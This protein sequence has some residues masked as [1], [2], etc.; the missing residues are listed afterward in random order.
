MA[1]SIKPYIQEWIDN[2]HT[3]IA[4][5][6]KAGVSE[7]VVSKILNN[8]RD[9]IRVSTADSILTALG[10]NPSVYDS[11]VPQPPESKYYEE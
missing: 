9:M 2:G 4:L 6:D 11:L 8:E 10:V 7:S 3:L 5:A 1:S